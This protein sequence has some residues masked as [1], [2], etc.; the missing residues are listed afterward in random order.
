MNNTGFI[1][2]KV[3]LEIID[4]VK[5]STTE[6]DYGTPR[7]IKRT[8]VE[9]SHHYLEDCPPGHSLNNIPRPKSQIFALLDHKTCKVL[10]NVN[11]K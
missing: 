6:R 2:L 7:L 5:M 4:C 1:A 3:H 8:I 10:Q 9:L 11:F